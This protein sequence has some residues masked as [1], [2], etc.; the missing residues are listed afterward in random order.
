[1]SSI[2]PHLFLFFLFYSFFFL[3]CNFVIILSFKFCLR[4]HVNGGA[5]IHCILWNIIQCTEIATDLRSPSER[6]FLLFYFILL[7]GFFFLWWI[8]FPY[9]LGIFM[10]H[11][12]CQCLLISSA[13][14]CNLHQIV[15]NAS[16]FEL[17]TTDAE[18]FLVYFFFVFSVFWAD[19]ADSRQHV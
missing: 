5:S 2:H 14:G 9:L 6:K 12:H 17:L 4:G 18:Q 8:S 11:H 3:V 19:D 15:K 13:C 16:A 10:A 1:M 7:M